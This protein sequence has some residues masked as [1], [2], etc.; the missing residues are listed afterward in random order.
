MVSASSAADPTRRR[1]DLVP[2]VPSL[3]GEARRRPSG[4]QQVA[5]ADRLPLSAVRRIR[6]RSRGRRYLGRDLNGLRGLRVDADVGLPRA[7]RCR[8]GQPTP[9]PPRR[10]ERAQPRHPRGAAAHRLPGETAH[11]GHTHGQ[12]EHPI[13]RTGSVAKEPFVPPC[14][15]QRHLGPREPR[16][17]CRERGR[18][19]Q[20]VADG[21]AAQHRDLRASVTSPAIGA[22][23]WRSWRAHGAWPACAASGDGVRGRAPTTRP[24][25]GVNAC[26]RSFPVECILRAPGHPLDRVG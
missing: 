13:D 2:A 4:T 5:V 12:H 25:R 15:E 24:D 6:L 17:Q 9:L 22:S 11:V 19:R 16:S 21:V 14:T 3:C 18:G 10:D 1:P 7:S 20:V 23:G 26:L 8:A